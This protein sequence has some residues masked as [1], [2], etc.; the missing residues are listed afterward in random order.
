MKQT[1]QQGFGLLIVITLSN[2]IFFEN[3][4]AQSENDLLA[5]NV[6]LTSKDSPYYSNFYIKDSSSFTSDYVNDNEN[7]YS[8]AELQFLKVLIAD[9]E[10]ETSIKINLITFNFS[11]IEKNDSA[12][13]GFS[14]PEINNGE[15]NDNNKVL[16]KICIDRRMMQIEGCDKTHKLISPRES[17]RIINS[18]FIPYFEKRKIFEG[19]INGLKKLMKQLK[20]K[21]IN[22]TFSEQEKNQ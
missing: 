6:S 4:K 19:S 3:A 17:R 16:I 14:F 13:S 12:E 10:S 11:M 7:I 2:F 1:L 20:S 8:E 22:S 18:A 5:K 21:K 9:F 15:T